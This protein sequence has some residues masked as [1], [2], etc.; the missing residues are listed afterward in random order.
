MAE[1]LLEVHDLSVSFSVSGREIRAVR[2]ASFS[3][4]KG[5][6]VALVGESGSGKSVSALSVLQLLPYPKASHPSGS[7]RFRGREI[8]G[9]EE[10]VLRDVRGDDISMIFQEPMTSLNPLHSVERQINETLI[11]HKGLDRA[12]ARLRT[13]ELLDLVGLRDAALRLT[14]YPHELSGGERQRVMI[15]MALA[16]EPD[17]LI[18]DEPT[19]ALDVTIQAQILNL[20]SELRRELNSAMILITHDL[21]VVAEMADDVLVMYAGKAVEYGGVRTIFDHPQHPYTRGLMASLIR[22]SDDK[23]T[24]LRPIPGVPPDLIDLPSGCAYRP[25]CDHAVERCAAEYP[26]FRPGPDGHPVA[27]HRVSREAGLERG[28]QP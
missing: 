26:A 4:D 6:T 5:E 2:H 9:A 1:K 10:P 28:A 17:L 21:G 19:T 11:L 18:A 20:L 14:A 12:A 22:L 25:R 3:I 24:A 15:A 7:I 13:L 16:N 23:T 27:C 8:M